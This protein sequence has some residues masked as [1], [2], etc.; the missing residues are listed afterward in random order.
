[1]RIC[2]ISKQFPPEVGGSGVYSYEIANAMGRR[3]HDVDVWTQSHPDSERILPVHENVSV[4]HV[5][6]ARRELVT[7]ETLFFSVRAQISVNF[8]KY[9]V[10]HGTLM[11]ASPICLRTSDISPPIVV[12][13]HGTSLGEVRSH[14]LNI[15][16]DFLKMFFFHPMNYLMDALTAPRCDR[17]IA[18]S[19]SA[20]EE[21]AR[22]YPINRRELTHVSHGVDTERF[23]PR[24]SDIKDLSSELFQLLYVGRLVSRKHVGLAIKSISQSE[25]KTVE[26]L[27]A[28][29]GRHRHRLEQ[30]AKR[31]DV[32]SQVKFLGYVS[33]NK[34]PNL[35]STVDM[36]MFTS[37]YEGFG[38]TFLEAMSSG[39]PVIGTPVGGFP[40]LVTHNES[41]IIVNR[42]SAEIANI[43]NKFASSE[44]LVTEMSTN[45]RHV[46][47]SRTWDTVAAETEEIYKSVIE[48]L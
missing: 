3:G 47:E 48:N 10:I 17:I 8:S 29:T 42:N 30:K 19:S 39:T 6:T 7:F 44:Q 18:I 41:G 45:A 14:H 22:F 13:S 25:N 2:I 16:T 33:D 46:A 4:Q 24:N 28:G 34:L 12:T 26:L 27:I 23:S 31:L 5:T 1:M 20:K 11:P 37:R 21:L 35:Y 9:D 36:F 32:D 40:D 15:P 38:L 43:I